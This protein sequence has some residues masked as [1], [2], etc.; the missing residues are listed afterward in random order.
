MTVARDIMTGDIQY[1]KSSASAR[2][3]ASRLEAAGV[4]A[5]PVCED[6]GHL[7]GMVTDRD[8][9]IK[10][11][12]AGRDAEE[13]TLAELGQESEVVTIGADDSLDEVLETMKRHQV[14]RLPVIDG[15]RM[16]GVVSQADLAR[17]ISAE[18]IG[19][20]VASISA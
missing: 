12:A 16:V 6:D 7:T 8:I 11:V 15:D 20:L 9:A 17:Q 19:D 2:E 4:G 1:L 18:Q 3:A 13:T 5:I 14:R 10:V